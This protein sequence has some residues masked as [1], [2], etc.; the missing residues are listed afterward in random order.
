MEIDVYQSIAFVSG[1]LV[2]RDSGSDTRVGLVQ[3]YVL[4]GS[5]ASYFIF[6]E[7]YF[8]LFIVS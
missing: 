2:D 4:A 7:F 8:W 6:W 5:P 3:K 1:A